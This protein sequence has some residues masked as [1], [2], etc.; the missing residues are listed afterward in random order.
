MVVI[1]V[2]DVV[3]VIADVV[4]VGSVTGHGDNLATGELVRPGAEKY[5]TVLPVFCK[6]C[7]IEI[8]SLDESRHERYLR[9]ETQI[10]KC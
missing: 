7:S 1:D 3:D 4:D 5:P 9:H 8:F 2:A 6:I 10:S